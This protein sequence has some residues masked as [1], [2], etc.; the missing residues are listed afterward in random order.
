MA[1]RNQVAVQTH[2]NALDRTALL[3]TYN[4]LSCVSFQL[5]FYFMR[6]YYSVLPEITSSNQP[7][8]ISLSSHISHKQTTLVA[9]DCR[10][11]AIW[12]LVKRIPSFDLYCDGS[13]FDL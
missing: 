8:I 13:W 7:I 9:F 10:P 11:H 2:S 5:E 4:R 6:I 1:A 3:Q 12:T